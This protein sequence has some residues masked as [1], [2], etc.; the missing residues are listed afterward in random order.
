MTQV[1]L[2]VSQ[3]VPRGCKAAKRHGEHGGVVAVCKSRK[4]A[5][6]MARLYASDVAPA[7]IVVTRPLTLSR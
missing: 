4:G 7:R 2:V 6:R 3:I 1:W 5:E